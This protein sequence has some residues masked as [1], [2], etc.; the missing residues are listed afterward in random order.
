MVKHAQNQARIAQVAVLIEKC[1]LSHLVPLGVEETGKDTVLFSTVLQRQGFDGVVSN[2]ACEA[3]KTRDATLAVLACGVFRD[4]C[5]A[6]KRL[7]GTCSA[8]TCQ[9]LTKRVARLPKAGQK[10]GKA[11]HEQFADV[12][13]LRT[14]KNL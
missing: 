13:T 5:C 2:F 4:T 3:S 1:S 10:N 12:G 8:D 11:E 6:D 14:S 7:L 9:D